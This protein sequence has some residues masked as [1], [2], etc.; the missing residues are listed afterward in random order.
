MS[1]A[2][3]TSP[4]AAAS[5]ADDSDSVEFCGTCAFS[6]ACISSGYNKTALRDLHV[7]IEHVGPFQAGDYLFR[8]GD[9]FNAIA[10]VRAGVVKTTVVDGRVASRCLDFICPAR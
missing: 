10:A 1:Q 2:T 7:L 3:R 4:V 5:I 6:S 9:A 8:E